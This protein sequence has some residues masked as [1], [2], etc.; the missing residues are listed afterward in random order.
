MTWQQKWGKNVQKVILSTK[1]FDS[2][3]WHGIIWVELYIEISSTAW[4]WK[5]NWDLHANAGNE[6]VKISLSTWFWNICTCYCL[7]KKLPMWWPKPE[8]CPT[9]RPCYTWTELENAELTKILG[10]DSE[11][12][13]SRSD[14]R[15]YCWVFTNPN[16][17]LSQVQF[18]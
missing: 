9:Q 10:G 3:S 13:N 16:A 12:I 1:S 6:S 15:L 18:A 7:R 17:E 5:K 8:C 4:K 14:C 11:K 2:Y